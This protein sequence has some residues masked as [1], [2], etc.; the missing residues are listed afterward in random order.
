MRQSVRRWMLGAG[1]LAV[2]G[3]AAGG[4]AAVAGAAQVSPGAHNGRAAAVA[5]YTPPTKPLHFG[6]KGAAVR[7]VQRRLAQLHYYP[8]PI[9]GKFGQDVLEAAW[10]FREVQGLRM[11]ATRAAQP[12]DKAFEHDLIHPKQPY[13]RYPK[14]GASRIEINQ[15]IEVLVLYRAVRWSSADKP[16]ALHAG[17]SASR[18]GRRL[19]YV[20]EISWSLRSWWRRRHR[21]GRRLGHRA[22][23]GSARAGW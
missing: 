21:G 6:Q 10:A 9:D 12:I 20:L 3:A 23:C 15:N 17:L 22:P 19:P 7:S 5:A 8:G 14:G 18:S 13:A 16:E 1:T 2:V 11:N 4:Q